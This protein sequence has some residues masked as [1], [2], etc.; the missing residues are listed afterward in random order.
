MNPEKRKKLNW[1]SLT[2]THAVIHGLN[3]LAGGGVKDE[4]VLRKFLL[5]AK[6]L[7]FKGVED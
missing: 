4:D 3:D 1:W 2:A 6:N 5:K 7:G